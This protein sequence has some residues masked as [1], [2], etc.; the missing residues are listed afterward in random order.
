MGGGCG[1]FL[2]IFAGGRANDPGPDSLRPQGAP[3]VGGCHARGG[4]PPPAWIHIFL[5]RSKTDQFGRGVA[6]YVRATGN[7]LCPVTALVEY[8]AVRRETPGPFFHFCAM[9]YH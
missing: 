8:V 6:V 4:P 9:G 3:G 7:E 1:V 2:W 5:K